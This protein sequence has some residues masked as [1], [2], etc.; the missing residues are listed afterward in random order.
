MC[1]RYVRKS[2]SA[3]YAEMFGVDAVPG[4]PS[5]NVA[6]TQSVAAVRPSSRPSCSRPHP[7]SL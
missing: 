3:V 7:N 4:T 2:P 1:G 6:P 5:Y